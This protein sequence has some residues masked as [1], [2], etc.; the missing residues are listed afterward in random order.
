[1]ARI[2][3]VLDLSDE[4][5][6]PRAAAEL[7]ARLR[8]QYKSVPRAASAVGVTRQAFHDWLNGH[9]VTAKHIVAM[10]ALLAIG[11]DTSLDSVLDD[12]GSA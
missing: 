7:A 6:R 3:L 1:V 4:E 8:A 5:S 10:F 12:K 11:D 9:H 2:L